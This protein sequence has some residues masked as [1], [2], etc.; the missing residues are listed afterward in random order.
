MRE[1]FNTNCA[2]ELNNLKQGLQETMILCGEI[3]GS[4]H[5]NRAK[6]GRKPI[7]IVQS[8]LMFAILSDKLFCKLF[9]GRVGQFRWGP[10][11]LL[12]RVKVRNHSRLVVNKRLYTDNS[13]QHLC[14][15]FGR[16][17]LLAVF[18]TFP[19]LV[20]GWGQLFPIHQSASIIIASDIGL[21][22]QRKICKSLSFLGINSVAKSITISHQFQICRY[23]FTIRLCEP[24]K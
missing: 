1:V 2:V 12:P 22:I 18:I 13:Y 11:L 14:S 21:Q 23:H 5:V 20:H 10:P 4:A 24:K 9:L 6:H 3:S 16:K 15:Y 17:M 8:G 7:L 19:E